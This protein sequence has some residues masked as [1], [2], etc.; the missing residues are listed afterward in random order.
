[1]RTG[2]AFCGN[3]CLLFKRWMRKLVLGI[4][5]FL[6]MISCGEEPVVPTDKGDLTPISVGELIEHN[7]FKLAYSEEHEQALWVFYQLTIDM[8]SGNINR[9]DDFREDPLVSTLSA[10]LNDYKGSGYD[11]GHLCPAASMSFNET[12][13]SESFFMSN[14]SPQSPSCNRGK[15]KSLE[16][17]IRNWVLTEDTL[18]VV[19]GPIFKDNLGEIGEDKVTIPGYYYKVIY[20]PNGKEKMI[21]FI[22]P[23]AKMNNDI[24]YYAVSVDQ[25]ELETGI[26]FF[27]GLPDEKENLMESVFDFSAWQ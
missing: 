21:G 22:M 14:M 9:T 19:S 3:V 2:H 11:R 27:S 23:N 15:W 20:D 12:S 8:V 24:D 25:V 16:T 7:Y 5:L 6:A 17:A 18:W 4:A 13:M 10:T 26:D 1:M